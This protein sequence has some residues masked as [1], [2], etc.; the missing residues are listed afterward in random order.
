M[1]LRSVMKKGVIMLLL[2]N[3]VNGFSQMNDITRVSAVQLNATY[4]GDLARNFNG[5][6]ATGSTYMGLADLFVSFDTQ[7]AGLWKGGEFLIHGA[8]THGGELTTNLV[9][10]F[11]GV[12]NIEAGNHTFLYELWFRQTIASL[13]ATIGLQDLN[14]EF[15]NSE[16]SSLFLNSSF[17]VHSV[18]A[19]NIS[20]PIF[21][22]TKPGITLS[23]VVSEKLTL[24]SAIYKGCPVD[25]ELNPYNLNWNANYEEGLLWISEGEYSWTGHGGRSSVLK[26]GFFYHQ[27]C[28]E[29]ESD[30]TGALLEEHIEKDYGVYLVGEHQLSLTEGE[31]QG[32]KIFYQAG[33][34]PRNDNFGYFGAGCSYTG[35]LS[36]KGSDILGLAF[37]ESML[38]DAYGNN[39]T[40]FELTY[41]VQLN[42]QIYLQPDLQYVMHPGGTGVKL[43]NATVGFLR[44]GMEF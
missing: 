2:L 19:G 13:T 38:T 27:H 24:K 9:G 30:L 31:N 34:S 25:F 21:P 12:S 7:K 3:A 14:V 16:V 20:A 37:A 22:V 32:L 33:L 42:D 40:T 39:E 6:I 44:L 23:A 11:Q 4:K 36:S 18:I 41:K 35:L 1:G 29:T 26:G 43:K 5:G 8:N 17:G 15:A 28:P 10:D